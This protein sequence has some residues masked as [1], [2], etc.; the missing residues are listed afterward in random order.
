MAPATFAGL[1]TSLSRLISRRTAVHLLLGSAAGGL[2]L[3]DTHASE[4]RKKGKGRG[5]KKSKKGRRQGNKDLI[6]ICHQQQTLQ[7]SSPEARVHQDHGDL[8]GACPRLPNLRPG[9]TAI[10]SDTVVLRVTASPNATIVAELERGAVV[11]I[12]GYMKT[13]GGMAWWPVVSSE[14]ATGLVRAEFL[15]ESPGA[16]PTP[17]MILTAVGPGGSPRIHGACY[18]VAKIGGASFAFDVCDDDDGAAD[19]AV[20]V[21]VLIPGTYMVSQTQA[22]DGYQPDSDQQLEMRAGQEVQLQFINSRAV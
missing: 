4:A 12:T 2:A 17:R 14:G 13:S 16:P 22:V 18:H 11:L 6:T 7:V 3:L 10:V 5:R 1:G 8:L 21:S 15:R 20:T 19:G 9:V